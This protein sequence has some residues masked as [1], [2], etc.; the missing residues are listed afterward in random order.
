MEEN[1]V[2]PTTESQEEVKVEEKETK[3]SEKT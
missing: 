2:E 3:A 1:K